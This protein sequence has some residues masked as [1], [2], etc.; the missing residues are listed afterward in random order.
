MIWILPTDGNPKNRAQLTND[1]TAVQSERM[2]VLSRQSACSN[3]A[4]QWSQQRVV[5]P[6]PARLEQKSMLAERSME[7]NNRALALLLLWNYKPS[8][9]VTVSY[10]ADSLLTEM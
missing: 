8:F 3:N 6:E 10:F 2:P 7:H 9:L 5:Q 4:V 1:T